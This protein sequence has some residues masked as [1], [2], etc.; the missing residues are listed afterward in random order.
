MVT[1]NIS[2]RQLA[3]RPDLAFVG[4]NYLSHL[5]FSRYFSLSPEGVKHF[6]FRSMFI[7]QPIG[8]QIERPPCPQGVSIWWGGDRNK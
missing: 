3:V 5:D 1:G 7:E 2:V 8:A 4:I 6:W